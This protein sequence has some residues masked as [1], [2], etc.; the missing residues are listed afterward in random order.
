M[1]GIYVWF[2]GVVEVERGVGEGEV[3]RVPWV[4]AVRER[5][6]FVLVA[7]DTY[8]KIWFL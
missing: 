5:S 2:A 8:F 4:L 1:C 3:R 7:W 6:L